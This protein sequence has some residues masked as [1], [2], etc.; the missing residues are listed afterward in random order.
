MIYAVWWKKN[1]H[2]GMGIHCAGNLAGS[3]GML[4]VILVWVNRDGLQGG[5]SP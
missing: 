5:W 4:A 3:F 2:P 1:E